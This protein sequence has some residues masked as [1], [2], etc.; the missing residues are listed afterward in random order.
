MEF[1][2]KVSESEVSMTGSVNS[3]AQRMRGRKFI[4]TG[5]TPGEPYSSVRGFERG[6]LASCFPHHWI[7]PLSK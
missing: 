6:N 5:V 1:V 4:F 7:V 2:E 3:E